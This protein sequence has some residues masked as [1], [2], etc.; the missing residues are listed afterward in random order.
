MDAL[1]LL[2]ILAAIVL[3]LRKRLSVGVTMLGAGLLGALLY[4]L[5][6]SDVARGYFDLVRSERFLSLTA[7]VVAITILGNLLKELGYLS[8]L[9]AGARGLY[10]GSKTAVAIM[11]GLVGLMPMPGGSLLS[12]P[13]VNSVLDHP[14]YSPEMK[15]AANYWFRHLTEFSWP[16]YAG[17]ILTEAIT[18]LPIADVAL[19]QLPL[20]A[21]MFL[22]GLIF[23]VSRIK[24]GTTEAHHLWRPLV[25]IASSVW[26]VVLAIAL[27][28]ILEVDLVI[29]VAA[30][31][32]LVMAISRPSRSIIWKSVKPGL[33][34]ELILLIFGVLSFQMVIEMSGGVEAVSKLATDYHLPVELVVFAV[35]FT[36]GLLTG[37]VSAYVGLGYALLAGLLYQPTLNPGLIMIAYLSG[38][39]GMILSPAHLC[40]ILTNQYF[41][42][43]LM[44]VYRELLPPLILLGLGGFLLYFLGWGNLFIR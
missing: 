9:A 34:P 10:G 23:F 26:P 11:P 14:R 19:L 12:A 43:D 18:G 29:S 7:L 42:S 4:W 40:L 17:L 39:I 22:L 16:V 32:L 20:A 38:F 24:D 37:M 13:L 41:G 28:G 1:K 6:A 44:K 31:L 3:A 21:L 8:R 2:V 5:P 25:A 30:S 33:S 27:Y 36:V 35:V 15:C